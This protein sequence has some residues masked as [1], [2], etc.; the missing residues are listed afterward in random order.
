MALAQYI[1]PLSRTLQECLRR[2]EIERGA[3]KVV[4]PPVEIFCTFPNQCQ[5]LFN[6]GNSMDCFYCKPTVDNYYFQSQ[7]ISNPSLQDFS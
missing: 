7:L 2:I 3:P 1:L 5:R 4:S 6:S